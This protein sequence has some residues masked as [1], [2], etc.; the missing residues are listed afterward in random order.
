[1]ILV[2]LFAVAWDFAKILLRVG[3]KLC[4]IVV[5]Q[6]FVLTVHHKRVN[7][8]RCRKNPELGVLVVEVHQLVIDDPE[9]V[10]I[11]LHE[12]LGVRQVGVCLVRFVQLPD[13]WVGLVFVGTLGEDALCIAGELGIVLDGV[14]VCQVLVGIVP[15]ALLRPR[16]PR[17][18]DV[19][20][21]AQGTDV[22]PALVLVAV[23]AGQA[24]E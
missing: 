3:V 12:K 8:G 7:A 9:R 16:V 5:A 21:F 23:G 14:P 13:A 4:Y 15:T 18:L 17:G 24:V 2:W 10:A 11:L 22:V 6:H 19:Q 20:R 1:M